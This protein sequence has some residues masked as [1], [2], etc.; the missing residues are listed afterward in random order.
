M[1]YKV[2]LGGSRLLFP[3]SFVKFEEFSIIQ[4]AKADSWFSPAEI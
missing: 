2:A 4:V 3:K 1:W